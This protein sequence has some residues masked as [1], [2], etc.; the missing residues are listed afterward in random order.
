MDHGD[1]QGNASD[2][3]GVR[4]PKIT[5]ISVKIIVLVVQYSS[6]VLHCIASQFIDSYITSRF[7]KFKIHLLVHTLKVGGQLYEL[8]HPNQDQWTPEQPRTSAG[9]RSE[10]NEDTISL[11]DFNIEGSVGEGEFGKACSQLAR[12]GGTRVRW[13]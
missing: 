10:T 5:Q 9:S 7:S 13:V 3:T 2:F 4:D 1:F 11:N 8:M 12:A 6:V